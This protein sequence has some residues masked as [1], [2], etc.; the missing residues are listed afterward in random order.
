MNKTIRFLFVLTL[1]LITVFCSG[2]A[3]KSSLERVQ[4]SLSK[5]NAEGIAKMSEA[6]NRYK[7]YEAESKGDTYCA[8]CDKYIEGKVRICT[9][10]GQYIK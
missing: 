7:Y 8:D 9:Y 4:E 2:C 10:C 3:K 6:S 1:I 5:T